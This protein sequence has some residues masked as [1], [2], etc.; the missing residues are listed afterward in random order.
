MG[1][2]IEFLQSMSYVCAGQGIGYHQNVR[3]VR[4]QHVSAEA[5]QHE[6]DQPAPRAQLNDVLPL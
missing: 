3:K 2:A 1:K 5:C 4:Q 6:A